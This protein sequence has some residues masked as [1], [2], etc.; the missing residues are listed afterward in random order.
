MHLHLF[1]DVV[2]LQR[3]R[4]LAI[5]EASFF[6]SL[7]SESKDLKL[8][9]SFQCPPVPSPRQKTL[10]VL[11]IIVALSFKVLTPLVNKI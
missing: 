11:P 6:R 1:F 4:I 9:F 8:H 2:E 10:E 5:Q 7:E 3:E